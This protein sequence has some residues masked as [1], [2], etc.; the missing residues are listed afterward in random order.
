MGPVTR[1]LCGLLRACYVIV[2]KNF[3]VKESY[4]TMEVCLMLY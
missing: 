4:C 2:Q 3:V 1:V